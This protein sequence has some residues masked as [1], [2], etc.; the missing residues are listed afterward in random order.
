MMVK[1]YGRRPWWQSG[2]HLLALVHQE[3]TIPQQKPAAVWEEEMAE[4]S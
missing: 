4:K 1:D 2:I 3:R